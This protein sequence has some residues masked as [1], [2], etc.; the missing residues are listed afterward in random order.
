MQ[1]S[2]RKLYSI[3]SLARASTVGGTSR[4]DVLQHTSSEPTRQGRADAGPLI[5]F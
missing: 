1:R 3:T 4:R 2:K 5:E